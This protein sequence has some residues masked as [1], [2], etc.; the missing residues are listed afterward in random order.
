[1]NA[2]GLAHGRLTVLDMPGY[3][4]GSR[5]EW[6]QEIQRYLTGRQQL[7][8]VFVLLDAQ[9]G[10][11][12]TDDLILDFLSRNSV[13]HQLVLS[14]ADRVL[15][16]SGA[17]AAVGAR[18]P[19][20]QRLRRNVDALHARLEDVRRHVSQPLPTSSEDGRERERA[21]PPPLGEILAVST[22]SSKQVKRSILGA[23]PPLL[24]LDNLRY[25]VL[26]AVGLEA[27]GRGRR[28]SL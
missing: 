14:K 16:P 1:M 21:G 15:Y 24:G 25:A 26:A 10:I 19:S 20:E 9:R 11:M 23:G 12:A 27:D 5:G 13:A 28:R 6:G 3:G 17:G 2:F 8:R 18:A 4:R 22:K 7:R